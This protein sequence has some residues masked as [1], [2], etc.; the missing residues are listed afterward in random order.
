[1]GEG[2]EGPDRKPSFE[3]AL[4]ELEKIVS[5]LESEKLTLDESMRLFEQGMALSRF[6]EEL[7]DEAQRRI[8]T[9]V[10]REGTVAELEPG[11]ALARGS[12]ET[13]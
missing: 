11:E 9:L 3:E 12:D 1:M 8:E 5:M 13:A 7:L 2:Q 6:C 4:A 10:A